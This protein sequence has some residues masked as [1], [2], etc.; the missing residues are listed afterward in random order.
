MRFNRA[1]CRAVPVVVMLAALQVLACDSAGRQETRDPS[2]LTILVPQD[3]WVLSPATR[4][5]AASF[6][7]FLEL[8]TPNQRGELEGRL[9]ESWEH[10]PGTREW[11]IH[12]RDDVR[13]HDGVSV[14][15]H[16]IAFTVNLFQHPDVITSTSNTG[17]GQ[18]ESVEVV[19]DHTLIMTYKPGSVW[20]TYWY[21]GYWH[22][23]YPKHLLEDLDPTGIA[24]WEFWKQPVGNGPFRY[25]R[26]SPKTMMEFEA[27]PDFFL[28]RPKIDRVVLKFGPESIDRVAGRER[29]CHESRQ[30]DRCRDLEER[31]AIQRLLRILG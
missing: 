6:L 3:E 5:W 29:R 28:G 13:W 23:F 27:N 2:T 9:A 15:A 10:V 4:G 30:P 7:V 21:P 16:D 20:H 14:T 17:F 12:L 19:D 31:S 25:V 11:T 1:A 18:V 8:A 24:E 26:H 22:V